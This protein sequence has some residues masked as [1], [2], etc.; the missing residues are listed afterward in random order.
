MTA[1]G[2]TRISSQPVVD[3]YA[4]RWCGHSQQVRRYLERN[5]I[6]YRFIDLERDPEAVRRLQWLTGGS[7]SHP[8]VVLG[9]E[10]L[11]EPS[12]AELDQALSV[13]P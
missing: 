7:A 2:S 8:T 13:R 6:P 9:D 5:R 3:L 11:V 10:V 4:T 1:L 12:I